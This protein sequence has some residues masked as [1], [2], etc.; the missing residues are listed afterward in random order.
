MTVEYRIPVIR[1]PTM[2]RSTVSNVRPRS[3]N[4]HSTVSNAILNNISQIQTFSAAESAQKHE[5]TRSCRHV[6][7]VLWDRQ[8]TISS[9]WPRLSTDTQ[10]E[11]LS[12][13]ATNS[14]K[15]T[16]QNS[17]V[18]AWLRARGRSVDEECQDISKDSCT[19]II[20]RYYRRNTDKRLYSFHPANHKVQA[21]VKTHLE[22]T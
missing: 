4:R 18:S 14:R 12:H 16:R 8:N 19:N 2:T 20:T 15:A 3:F 17:H 9:P 22:L 10:K 6:I 21:T 1:P 11:S 7:L 5:G 13:K